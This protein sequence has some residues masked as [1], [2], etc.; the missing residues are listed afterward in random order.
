MA[1]QVKEEKKEETKL[2][3]LIT[4]IVESP[5]AFDGK[6]RIVGSEMSLKKEDYESL[7]QYVKVKE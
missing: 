1:K 3:E 5:F 2:T 4:V 7:S 6:H